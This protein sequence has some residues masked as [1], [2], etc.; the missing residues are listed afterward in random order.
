LVV[1][2]TDA[3]VI[4]RISS[5][6][7]VKLEGRAGGRLPLNATSGGIAMLAFSDDRLL[8]E[9]L[10]T[11]PR[12]FTASTPVTEQ[13]LLDAIATVRRQGFIEL[14]EAVTPGVVSLAAPIV[15][16]KSSQ[17]AAVSVIVSAESDTRMVAPALRTTALAVARASAREQI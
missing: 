12:M 4:E 7:A 17:L 8:A 6:G 14:K 9:V 3:V 13:Q 11:P 1:D 10:R 16:S 15:T 2:G 5:A